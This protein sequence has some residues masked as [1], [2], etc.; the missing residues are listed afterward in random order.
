MTT[1]TAIFQA[2]LDLSLTA[3]PV[4]GAVLLARLCLRRAPKK[5][6]YALWAV[7][8]FRLICPAS[9]PSPMSLF[10]SAPVQTVRETAQIAVQQ[11]GQTVP[12]YSHASAAAG[13]AGRN[14]AG[15]AAGSLPPVVQSGPSSMEILAV[16][17]AVGLAA[18]LVWA[19]V[20]YL[21]I[22]R[23]VRQ[24]VL[25]EDGVFQCDGLRT[26][27]VLGC[28]RPKIYVPFRM[29]AD[30]LAHILLHER[31]HLRR[32]DPWWKLLGF[33][34]LAVYWWNPAV[35]LCHFLF[36]RDME[37]S[38]DEAVLRKMGPEV[39]Q[40]YS[41]SLVSFAAG[42]HFSAAGPLAF[43]END[44]K[45]RVKNILRWKRAAPAAVFLA[46]ALCLLAAVICGTDA[47]TGRGWAQN[48]GTVDAGGRVE[49]RFSYSVPHDINSCLFYEDVYDHGK[50]ISRNPV[51]YFDFNKDANHVDRRGTA[52]LTGYIND[53]F[54]SGGWYF[55]R[56]NSD[57]AKIGTSNPSSIPQRNYLAI[58][59][60]LYAGQNG[61]RTRR[62]LN[63]LDAVAVLFLS[64][65]DGSLSS[66]SLPF[67]T[68]SPSDL[69]ADGMTDVAAVLRVEFSRLSAEELQQ[70]FLVN[71]PGAGTVQD[72]NQVTLKNASGGIGVDFDAEFTKPVRSWAI[73][74]DVYDHGVLVSSTPRISDGFLENGT[75]VTPRQFSGTLLCNLRYNESVSGKNF[76]GTLDCSYGK[77]RSPVMAKWTVHLP[78]EGYNGAG[79]IPGGFVADGTGKHSEDTFSLADVHEAVLLTYAFSD[80]DPGVTVYEAGNN[81]AC[82]NDAAVQFRLVT[83]VEYIESSLGR[84]AL[85]LYSLKNPYVGDM[86]ADGK[87]LSALNIADLGTYKM[88]LFTSEQPYILQIDFQNEPKGPDA[89][90]SAM[91][92][93][94]TLLLALIGNL[95]EVRWTY[96]QTEDGAPTL[97][98][99]FFDETNAL[100][101]TGMRIKDCG[102]SLADLQNLLNYL[103]LSDDIQPSGTTEGVGVQ[104]I[105]T[106]ILGQ[107]GFI[108]QESGA[109]GFF[110]NYYIAQTGG[111]ETCI[112]ESWGRE[113]D[114][115]AVDV[116][117]DG[118]KELVCNV[119]Y[120]AD[121]AQR[122][123]VYRLAADG[124]VECAD[125]LE[126]LDVPYRD[127]GIGS[128]KE[129]YDAIYKIVDISYYQEGQENPQFKSYP[130]DMARLTFSPYVCSEDT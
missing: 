104:T 53:D 1:L 86:V 79:M 46:L 97:R 29:A 20:S 24:G 73:Y 21:H 87:L 70:Q 38:C 110:T 95:D 122:V 31:A 120:G 82:V 51:G 109:D 99:N 43:G 115:T 126:L 41:L 9:L 88:E 102:A 83:S 68:F 55:S 77:T 65:D 81:V 30:E 129:S 93:R 96:P 50:L 114:D 54:K 111:Q 35:W 78:S 105:F 62:P 69:F 117:G 75:G 85:Q 13:N 28:F 71:G 40:T 11:W 108:R 10:N 90:N 94:A 80:D 2:L 116:D 67:E 32:L 44:A 39:K 17:W 89:L 124:S 72:G 8:G 61:D 101:P 121:G 16:V 59:G 63:E 15:A 60:P 74:E 118:I 25:L 84:N 14:T 92:D 18:M 56:T 36:C 7:V 100:K 6:S 4:M 27:F 130:L 103:G 57:G 52:G 49:L 113:R 22:R 12:G 112:A 26:P 76:V 3:L 5:Y 107:N 91:D 127:G 66:S 98:T 34:I 123:V 119:T 19:V 48:E 128:L 58:S 64:D 23:S 106:D 37:M 33:G 42:R 47:P 125:P 45:S